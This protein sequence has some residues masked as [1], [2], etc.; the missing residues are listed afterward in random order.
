MIK[1]YKQAYQEVNDEFQQ[2]K[3]E[4]FKV[5]LKKYKLEQ[6]QF[7]ENFK[8]QKQDIE[9]K[10]RI[11]KLNL[12]NLDKGDFKAIEERM[13][14]SEKAKD[15]TQTSFTWI[16]KWFDDSWTAGTFPVGNKTFYF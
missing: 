10:L 7:Q 12:D 13:K 16:P 6:L 14:K 4:K 11:I 9:E 15:L 1:E 8:Q 2:Q 5:E 3:I